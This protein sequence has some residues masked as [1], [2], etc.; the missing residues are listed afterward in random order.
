MAPNIVIVDGVPCRRIAGK[1]W[2]ALD[3]DASEYAGVV[4]GTLKNWSMAGEITVRRFG[5]RGFAEKGS[6]D[7]KLVGDPT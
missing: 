7:R 4:P 6:L 1:L 5:R 2:I 3:P